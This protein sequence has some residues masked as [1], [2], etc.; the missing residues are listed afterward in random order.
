MINEE[1]SIYYINPFLMDDL[2]YYYE[3]ECETRFDEY[4]IIQYDMNKNVADRLQY[5]NKLISKKTIYIDK[6]YDINSSNFIDKINKTK[7]NLKIENYDEFN[8][9]TSNIKIYCKISE[10]LRQ[11]FH[12]NMIINECLYSNM[13]KEDDNYDIFKKFKNLKNF[14]DFRVDVG[15]GD[16]IITTIYF[17]N[18]KFYDYKTYL[19]KYTP[20]LIRWNTENNYYILNRDYEYIGFNV[21]YIEYDKKGESYLFNDGSKPWIKKTRVKYEENQ[22]LIKMCNEYEKIIKEKE[23]KECLNKNEFTQNIISLLN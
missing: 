7:F 17:I 4:I 18:Y 2:H 19:R 1:Y 8:L 5:F 3:N 6:I 14:D 20:Y 9:C 21:K 22:H 13:V 15:V 11:L 10:K 16:Y 23:L 12:C